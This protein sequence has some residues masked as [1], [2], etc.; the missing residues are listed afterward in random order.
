MKILGISGSLE[1]SDNHDAAAALLIDGKL[2]G[3]YEEERFN[4]IK[5]SYKNAFPILSIQRLLNENNLVLDDIDVIAIPHDPTARDIYAKQIVEAIDKNSKKV[6]ELVYQDHH[7]AHICDSVFQSG[8][9]HCACLVIDGMGDA[10]D[11]IT[12]AH[13]KDGKITIL[14][15]YSASNSIGLLY[16]G[17]T[18]ALNLGEFGEGKLM[19]LAP[20]GKPVEKV[21]LYWEDNQIKSILPNYLDTENV[22][23]NQF[24][25]YSRIFERYF[26]KNSYPYRERDIKQDN[27][28][29]YSN[30]A[31]SAQ[32]CYEDITLS[33]AKYLKELTHDT[34]L[35]LSGGC[36]QNCI[37]NSLIINANLFTDVFAGPAP[38]D[39]G[40]AAGLAFYGAYIKGENIENKR[41][42][43]SY[44][45]KCY[46][47]E[48][49]LDACIDVKV[50]NYDENKVVRDLQQGKIFAWFQGGSEIG[51]RALGHRSLIADPSNRDNLF[52]LND[53]IKHRENWRPLAPIILDFMFEKVFNTNNHQLCEF[54]LRTLT[55]NEKYRK[56]LIAVCHIDNS[57]RPQYLEEKDNPEMYSLMKHFYEFT[58]IPGIINTSFNDRGQ[59]IIETPE[60]AIQFL[61]EHE[62]LDGVIFNAKY[63]AMR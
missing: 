53:Y 58:E 46:T 28:M 37:A 17:A 30:I 9:D 4:R 26:I 21:P 11:G 13:Y 35:I 49:C 57:T 22:G 39:A 14:E 61:K 2:V 42:T 1:F 27:I 41:L 52:I 32:K 48:E 23:A 54:M 24:S 60:Q 63:V 6:P 45:G 44:V 43:N 51:P 59:P 50:S 16:A 18:G 62:Y 33:I 7:M 25:R 38:H 55:I 34:N 31:A 8:F 56:K 12:L 19:G 20:Y 10:K 3:N 5:H 15:K 29:Y 47:D 40:C 36:I